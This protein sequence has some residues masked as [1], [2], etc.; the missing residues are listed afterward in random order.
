MDLAEKFPRSKAPRRLSPQ[1]SPKSLEISLATPRLG[2]L[3]VSDQAACA[4]ARGCSSVG[5]ALESHSRGQGFDSPQLHKPKP[6][7]LLGSTGFLFLL[8]WCFLYAARTGQRLG[9]D[10]RCAGF[11]LAATEQP[12]HPPRVGLCAGRA[13]S[14][15]RPSAPWLAHRF[16]ALACGASRASAAQTGARRVA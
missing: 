8:W 1:K 14:V 7:L 2:L 3:L 15:H 6:V 13:S 9:N 4:F 11:G 12:Q 5:R 16:A 10:S